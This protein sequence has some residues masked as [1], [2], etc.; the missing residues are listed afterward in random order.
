METIIF[1]MDKHLK[2]NI[3]KSKKE[4]I[5]KSK[6]FNS[7]FKSFENKL[8]KKPK[9]S[10]S[11]G[12]KEVLTQKQ[13]S[14]EVNSKEKTD[15][16]TLDED[17]ENTK[18]TDI[19]EDSLIFENIIYLL[20]NKVNTIDDII[21]SNTKDLE[22]NIS[23]TN[24]VDLTNR[25][26]F[27]S[28]IIENLLN[29]T[30]NVVSTGSIFKDIMNKQ[31]TEEELSTIMKNIEPK[32]DENNKDVNFDINYNEKMN[33]PME[34]TTELLASTSNSEEILNNNKIYVLNDE[35]TFEQGNFE[36]SNQNNKVETL[37]NNQ[38]F[39]PMEINE[40]LR[41][42]KIQNESLITFG[43]NNSRYL[44]N[45][46]ID[47][48]SENKVNSK[49]VIQQIVDKFKIDTSQSKNEIT[50]KLKPEI[51][52]KMTMSIEIV[53]DTIIAKLIVENQKVKDIIEGNLIQLRDEIKDSG[54]EIKTFE[55]FVGNSSD[56][57]KHN[58]NQFNLK[59]SNK[60]IKIKNHNAKRVSDYAE[61]TI[62]NKVDSIGLYSENGLNL[63][64]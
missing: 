12:N 15:L 16:K 13:N 1:N 51:L 47:V 53:K 37:E 35:Q 18:E 20:N 46:S 19:K 7:T 45:D 62:E 33:G 48:E 44:E 42:F 41:K 22:N 31:I 17:V 49:E 6:D 52:G 26:V 5:P 58:S 2:S 60:K 50:L 61:S 11:V 55:V 23:A 38:T 54:L 36:H 34:S 40:D 56:F 57:D 3:E 64:A 32:N 25:D 28:Q 39:E 27:E 9:L 21:I 14:K 10:K 29:N 59:Q 43:K 30:K 4:D 63:L 24:I 8:A